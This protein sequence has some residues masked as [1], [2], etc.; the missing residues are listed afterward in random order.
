MTEAS[1]AAQ[2]RAALQVD[3]TSDLARAGLAATTRMRAQQA[4]VREAEVALQAG[5]VPAA[6][7]IARGGV[8]PRDH[9]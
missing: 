4:R 9:G 5:D 6:E 7:R 8:R 1:S 3:G 2:Y